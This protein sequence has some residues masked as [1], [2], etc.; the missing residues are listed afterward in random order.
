MTGSKYA[1]FHELN[2]CIQIKN[3]T[4]EPGYNSTTVLVLFALAPPFAWP[5][6]LSLHFLCGLNEKK[7][8]FLHCLILFGSLGMLAM[9]ANLQP[10][11]H[12][13]LY[14]ISLS[15]GDK[16]NQN[17]PSEQSKDQLKIA[18]TT[19]WSSSKTSVFFGSL[20]TKQFISQILSK[21]FN[22]SKDENTW[23]WTCMNWSCLPGWQHASKNLNKTFNKRKNRAL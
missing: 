8:T 16:G 17:L 15:T 18:S 21:I 6:L 20:K 1:A 2:F 7:Q 19:I 12:S 3:I 4:K 13:S 11:D 14:S 23:G 22:Q 10:E 5:R 9:Q